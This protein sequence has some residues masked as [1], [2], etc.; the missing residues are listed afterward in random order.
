MPNNNANQSPNPQFS[1][2]QFAR[3]SSPRGTALSSKTVWDTTSSIPLTL[4][5]PANTSYGEMFFVKE[6]NLLIKKGTDLGNN[7]FEIYHDKAYPQA[8]I[9]AHSIIELFGFFDVHPSSPIQ[10]PSST[11][12][13][14]Q[15]DKLILELPTPIIVRSSTQ[16]VFQ[17]RQTNSVGVVVS[18]ALHAGQIQANILGWRILETNY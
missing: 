18:S 4:Q 14:D 10:D 1:I 2:L 16:D 6:I 9:Q 8:I 13:A 5:P 7:V 12:P 3:N 15:Y 17:I 11:D